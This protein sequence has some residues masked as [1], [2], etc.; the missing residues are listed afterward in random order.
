MAIDILSMA[1]SAQ[2]GS[3]ARAFRDWRNWQWGCPVERTF[4]EFE[5]Y[6]LLQHAMDAVLDM[7]RTASVSDLAL[8][9]AQLLVDGWL[10]GDELQ[11]LNYG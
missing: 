3:D 6:N 1:A 4:M 7:K 10:P 8:E 5:V 9:A 11:E 2:L